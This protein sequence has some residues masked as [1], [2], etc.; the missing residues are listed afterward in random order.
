MRRRGRSP[1]PHWTDSTR[2]SLAALG[3]R[4]PD[5]AAALPSFAYGA[6]EYM[7]VSAGFGFIVVILDGVA[8]AVMGVPG[9]FVRAVLAFVTNFIP[10][11]GFVIGVIPPPS[12]RY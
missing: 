1:P 4:M 7:G 6:G 2:R 9:A 5:L 3:E 10:Y 11:I 12:S 8:L